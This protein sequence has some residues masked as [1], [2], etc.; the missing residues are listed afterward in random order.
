LRRSAGASWTWRAGRQI[1]DGVAIARQRRALEELLKAAEAS[2]TRLAPE[3]AA[4]AVEHGATLI[5][6]RS[7][8]DRERDGIVPGSLHIPRTVLEWRLAGD[9]A[10]RNPFAPGINEQVIVICDHGCSSVLAAA[11]LAWLG[12]SQVSDVIGGYAAW[13]RAGLVTAPAP[14][15]RRGTRDLAGSRAPDGEYASGA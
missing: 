5:D 15:C 9:S 4:V 11:T 14:R 2:I 8:L 6:I 10:W 13:Q 12:F 3:D 7:D 1:I